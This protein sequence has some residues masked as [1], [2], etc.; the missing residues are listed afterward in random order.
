MKITITL[1]TIAILF[2]QGCGTFK[3]ALSDA[4]WLTGTL[5]ENITTK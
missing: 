4:S 2:V 5:S 1:L 3:G